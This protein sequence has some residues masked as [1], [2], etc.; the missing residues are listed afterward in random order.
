MNLADVTPLILTYNESPNIARTLSALAW[1]KQVLIIDSD[2]TDDTGRIAERVHG[3]RVLSREFDSHTGQWNF[4]LDQVRTEWTLALDADYVCGS[5][6]PGE[7]SHL[8]P[9]C[10]AF[11]AEFVYAFLGQSLRGTL[12]PP[13]IVL[14]R[15]RAFR[16]VQDGHTQALELNGAPT[17]RLR[18]KITH[19]D[20]KPLSRWLSAQS[21]YA[22]LE[23]EKLLQ[24][25]KHLLGW[26]DKLRRSIVW[27]PPLTFMYCL[28]WKRLLLDGWPGMYYAMQRTYAEILLSL[29]LLDRRLRARSSQATVSGDAETKTLEN[30]T[31]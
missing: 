12:Y 23:A 24:T 17:G 26:K 30:A 25:P 6:L 22:T 27:A 3:V 4:G 18:T 14:F 10:D 1:A 8:A 31:P 28:F 2:S 20:R 16:Y 5:E 9:Q 7:L 19:D 13:R 21:S 15:T 11:A 29:E